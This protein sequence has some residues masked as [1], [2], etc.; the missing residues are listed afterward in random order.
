MALD[1][2]LVEHHLGF[3]LRV[4]QTLSA[5]GSGGRL[6]AIADAAE[7]AVFVA[8]L[9]SSRASRPDLILLDWDLPGE[10]SHVLLEQIRTAPGAETIPVVVFST[11]DADPEKAWGRVLEGTGTRADSAQLVDFTQSFLNLLSSEPDL[12]NLPTWPRR[13]QRGESSQGE[14]PTAT[15]LADLVASVRRTARAVCRSLPES[16][17]ADAE[18]AAMV[19]L[20]EALRHFG[21]MEDDHFE[22]YLKLRVRGA[23][24]DEARRFDPLSRRMRNLIGR[25]ERVTSAYRREHGVDPEMRFVAQTLGME[26]D[27]CWQAVELSEFNTLPIHNDTLAA[28]PCTAEDQFVE[29]YSAAALRWA[30]AKLSKRSRLVLRL[31]YRRGL[32]VSAIA[33][34]LALSISRVHQL[35]VEAEHQLEKFLQSSPPLRDL[36]EATKRFDWDDHTDETRSHQVASRNAGARGVEAK[37]PTDLAQRSAT[38]IAKVPR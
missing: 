9:A 28:S 29:S 15:R 22:N 11:S 10:S 4:E 36:G 13:M 34:R 17:R 19:G 8:N 25:I 12:A 6:R 18:G 21:Q 26:E 1:V 30:L 38:S 20:V 24:R 2:L 16:M 23:I 7:A 5:E 3:V 31:W 37:K 32:T 14:Y 35:R 33:E 27:R